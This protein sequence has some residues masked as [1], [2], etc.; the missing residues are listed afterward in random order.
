MIKSLKKHTPKTLKNIVK[1]FIN[2]AKCVLWMG[3]SYYNKLTLAQLLKSRGSIHLGCGD[4]KFNN[5]VNIDKRATQA[6]DIVADCTKLGFIPDRSVKYIFSNAFLEH[7]YLNQRQK[8]INDLHRI[9]KRNGKV[10]ILSIPDFEEIA[11]AYLAKD[12]MTK[13]TLFDLHQAYRLTHGDPEQAPTWWQAQLHKTLFDKKTLRELFN[14][15]GFN[16]CIIFRSS[17]GD[18]LLPLSLGII[19]FK[20]HERIQ[21][22][23]D[24]KTMIENIFDEHQINFNKKSI[25]IL[26]D[27]T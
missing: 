4:I 20:S 2:Y 3:K 23:K 26:F 18:D 13:K 6:T 27:N 12:K 16:K 24:K 5:F 14:N 22:A 9:L 8:F 15:A 10:V 19:A 25:N 17:Y 11:R 1:M 21:K 7:L